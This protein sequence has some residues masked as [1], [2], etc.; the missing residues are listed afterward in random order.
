MQATFIALPTNEVRQLQAGALDANGQQPQIAISDGDGNP[1]R[2]CLREIPAGAP[3]LILAWRP[4]TSLQPYA[5]LGPIFLCAEACARHPED[6]GTP[7]L[8]RDREMLIRGYDA[9]ERII[10]GSGRTVPMARIDEALSELFAIPEMAFAHARS[11]ANN[12]YHFRIEA[13]AN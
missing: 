1:C 11:P 13:A 6:A 2:H 9:D 5:E 3:M 8:Y 10:Y 4:F 12:C 7:N